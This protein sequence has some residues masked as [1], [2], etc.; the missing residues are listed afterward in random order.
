MC[1][2]SK[3]EMDESSREMPYAGK[4]SP[5]RAKPRKEHEE[6]R[7]MESGNDSNKSEHVMPKSNSAL[8]GRVKLRGNKGKSTWTKSMVDNMKPNRAKPKTNG[9]ELKQ[10][11]L[12]EGG[13]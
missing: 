13:Y 1:A 9:L 7:G 2:K 3:M 10:V 4:A 5:S 8:P 12:C 11:G 6:P